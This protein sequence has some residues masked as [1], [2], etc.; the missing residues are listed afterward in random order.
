GRVG[1]GGGCILAW[2]AYRLRHSR[3]LSRRD[4][5]YDLVNARDRAR[6]KNTKRGAA[7]FGVCVDKA[8]GLLDDAID[9]RQPEPGTL[10]DFFGSKERFEYLLNNMRWNAGAGVT[11][12]NE[13]IVGFGHPF[14]GEFSAFL[15]RNV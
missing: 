3:G 15:G 9:R 12:F 4:L 14:I 6:Q 11:D 8:A 1:G 5:R 10:A 13:Y 2:G 7:R